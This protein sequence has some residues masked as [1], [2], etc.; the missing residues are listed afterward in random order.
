MIK[1]LKRLSIAVGFLMTVGSGSAFAQSLCASIQSSIS[2]GACTGTCVTNYQQNHPECFGSSSS[3]AGAS[4][5]IGVTSLQQML[6]ISNAASSRFTAFQSPRGPLADSGQRSGLAAGGAADK[7]NVWGNAGGDNS[8]YDG[9]TV[10]NKRIKSSL[11][12]TNLVI[13]GDYLLSSTL[14]VGASA[15]F[16]RGNGSGESIN[17]GVSNGIT[18]T[19]SNGYTLAP[20]VAWAINKDL[21]LDGTIG[22]GNLD[23][24]SSGNLTGSAKRLFYGANL[25]YT[26]W[27]GNWQV[28][29]KGSYLY[30]EEKYDDLKSNGA[31]MAN[32][33]TK[34]K[35]DQWR[36]GMQAGYW[37]DGMMPYFGVSYSTD[38]RSTSAAAAVQAATDDLGKSAWMWSLGLNF[39]SL[40]NKMTGGIAYNA[41][42][43]RSHAKR[44][45]L[46]ANIN[47]RF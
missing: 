8:E 29:G 35:I 39:I 2:S 45:N 4:Q 5:A 34:N 14:V 16:D 36:L 19:T 12:V 44:N 3:T 20:Y 1:Y 28:T 30:G 43:G 17:A 47:I 9:G 10:A 31:T 18:N 38:S 40:K 26:H 41:E 37:M 25:N 21:S 23:L 46:M 7:W 15:A 24:T 6:T 27:Y 32:T 13:G 11:D 33:A 42:S 22:W